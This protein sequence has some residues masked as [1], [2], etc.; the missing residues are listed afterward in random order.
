MPIQGSMV[1]IDSLEAK[2]PA[3]V[4]K[5]TESKSGTPGL[6]LIHDW[7]WLGNYVRETADRFASSGFVAIA[8]DLYVGKYAKNTDEAKELSSAVTPAVAK[9]FLDSTD[10]YLRALDVSRVG[11]TG[12]CLGGTIA[13]QYVCESTEIKAGVFFYATNLPSDEDL[14]NITSPLLIIYGD[15]D[16]SVNPERANQLEQTLKSLNKDA[17]L[18]TYAGAPHA[19]FNPENEKNYRPDAAKDAWEKTLEFFNQRHAQDWQ[20]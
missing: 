15:Q 1:V 16:H 11:I 7:W 14:K 19:F 20:A 8:P 12:F 10:V 5:L 2:L 18:L 3:Y 4:S 9:N 6:I 13:F 17:K